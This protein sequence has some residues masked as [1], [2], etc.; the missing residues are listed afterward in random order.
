MLFLTLSAQ[1]TQTGADSIVKEH[2]NGELKPYTIYAKENVQTGFE[3]TTATGEILELNYSCWVY[4]VNFTEVANNKYLIVK[5]SNG[6]LLGIN[7]KNDENLDDLEEWKIVAIEIPFE[8]YSL[9]GTSCQWINL[10]YS[11]S[12]ELITIYS[13]AE[14]ENHIICSSGNYPE[15]DFSK[16]TLLLAN[17]STPNGISEISKHLLQY[18]VNKYKLNIEI[19]LN[20]SDMV[21]FWITA[22][23][24]NKLKEESS[25]ELNVA[26]IIN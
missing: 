21:D 2:M 18:S 3:I 23:I 9:E 8:E 20:D 10:N 12:S 17:G 6:N 22:L 25:V 26:F 19:L 16:H 5:E 4:Y 1:V 24:V 7:P 11:Y 15:I 13:N 14:L